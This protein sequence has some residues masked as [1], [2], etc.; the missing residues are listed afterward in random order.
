MRLRQ[1]ALVARELDRSVEDLCAVLGIGVA[2]NDP[3]MAIFGLVNAVVPVGNTFLEVVS[4]AV[5]GTTA[6]LESK[7]V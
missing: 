6:G 1:V 2:H 5:G 3:N 7:V 4:P